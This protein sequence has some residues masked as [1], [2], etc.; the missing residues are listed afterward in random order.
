MTV[1]TASSNILTESI[2]APVKNE[3][4]GV[5]CTESTIRAHVCDVMVN[6]DVMNC[7]INVDTHK[8]T[9]IFDADCIA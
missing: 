7:E 5:N 6:D 2:T 1:S 8:Q 4:D 9:T 3:S